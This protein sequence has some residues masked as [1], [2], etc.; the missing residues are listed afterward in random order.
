MC[1]AA[2]SVLAAVAAEA[3]ALL[4]LAHYAYSEETLAQ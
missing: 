2:L 1:T 4:R 3:A